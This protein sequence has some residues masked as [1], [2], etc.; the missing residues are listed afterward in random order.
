MIY[1]VQPET[2]DQVQLAVR[3]AERLGLK[4]SNDSDI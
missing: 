4:L 1:V 2:T 3:A